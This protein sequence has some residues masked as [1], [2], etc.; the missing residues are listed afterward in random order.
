MFWL[1][2]Q[3]H[4]DVETQRDLVG[5]HLARTITARATSVTEA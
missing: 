3:T 1:N 4:Y 5:D 2:L